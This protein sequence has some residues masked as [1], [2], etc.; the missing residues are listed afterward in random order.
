MSTAVI[1]RAAGELL[2][3]GVIY[4]IVVECLRHIPK[5]RQRRMT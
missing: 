4:L 1:L 5:N 3:L 2:C